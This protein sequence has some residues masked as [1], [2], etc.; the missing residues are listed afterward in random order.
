MC[1]TELTIATCSAEWIINRFDA[2]QSS[3]NC[4]VE[5]M[6]S[7]VFTNVVHRGLLTNVVTSR[8]KPSRE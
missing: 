8:G 7:G 4:G 6:Q 5:A 2:K 3:G 1:D